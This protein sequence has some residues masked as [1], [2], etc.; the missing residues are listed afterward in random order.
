MTKAAEKAKAGADLFAFKI[1]PRHVDPGRIEIGEVTLPPCGAREVV[2]APRVVGICGS[3][4]HIHDGSMNFNFDSQSRP[5]PLSKSPQILGHEIAGTVVEVGSEVTDLSIGDRVVVDQGINCASRARGRDHWCEH[6]RA[7]F[8]H[9]CADYEEHGITGLPGGFAER[10]V[11]PAV[12]AI[13]FE[14]TLSFEDAAMTEPLGCV[15]HS[16]RLMSGVHGRRDFARGDVRSVAISGLGPS[17]QL[18]GKA[19]R[20]VLGFTGPIVVSDPDPTKRA[21]ATSSFDAI[22]V[23][24]RL[25]GSLEQAVTAALGPDEGVDVLVDACGSPEAWLEFPRVVGKRGTAILYGF[26]RERGAAGTLDALQWRGVEMVATSGASGP[27]DDD[28]RPGLYREALDHIAGGRVGVD[29]LVTHRHV[30]LE[31]VAT[32]LSDAPREPGYLKGVLALDA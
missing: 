10:I 1:A 14:G 27:I 13:A 8:S 3:D 7:G 20:G 31:Q 30:G 18:F 2:V 24:S 21:L 22:A 23:D 17:G 6:C 11:V 28:G 25:P 19:V 5:L 15:L 4:L 16:L 9:H 29:D 26:G 32:A 12:N